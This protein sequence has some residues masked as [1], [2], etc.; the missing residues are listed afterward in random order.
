MKWKMQDQ[1]IDIQLVQETE[2]DRAEFLEHT[3]N[4]EVWNRINKIEL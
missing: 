1:T 2:L 3:V 4:N